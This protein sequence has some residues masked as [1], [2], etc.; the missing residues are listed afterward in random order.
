MVTVL[1]HKIMVKNLIH[2]CFVQKPY[3]RTNYIESII[4]ENIN[5]KN[6][7]RIKKLPDPISTR[8]PASKNYV[9][10]KVNDPGIVINSELIELNDRNITNARFTQVNQWPQIDS[11]LTAKFS[12]DNT[13]S[14]GVD[15]SKT[16][17]RLDPDEK[18]NLD[19]Q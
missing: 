5:L 15:E 2:L 10:I 16:L 19:E 3:L 4:E 13:I 7:F 8:E 12:V 9:E 6:Q 18:M 11:H 17:L 1:P 14:N